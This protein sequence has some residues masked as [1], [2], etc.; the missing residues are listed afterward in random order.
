MNGARRTRQTLQIL[1]LFFLSLLTVSAAASGEGLPVQPGTHRTEAFR[2]APIFSD[3]MVLPSGRAV[4]VWG[5][6]VAGEK[7]TVSIARQQ[8]TTSIAADATWQVTLAAMQPAVDLTM[9][10][11]S[12]SGAITYA[13]VA[14]AK[15][16]PLLAGVCKQL[17]DPLATPE[18][19]ALFHN[20]KLYSRRNTLI[21]QQDPEV[22]TTEQ[23]GET[24]M[25][26]TTGSDPA[27]W[28]SDFMHI[29]HQQNN[30]QKNWFHDAQAQI[31]RR[32]ST[33]YDR[34]MVNIFCWHFHEPYEQKTFNAREMP[35]PFRKKAFRSLLPGGE[36][37]NWYKEKLQKIAEVVGAI[38]GQNG[39]LSPVIFRPFHEFDGDWFW[40]GKPYCSAQ[41]FRDCWRFTVQYLRDDLQVHNLLYAFSPDCHFKSEQ[42]YL[43]RYPG[44]AY[45]DVVGFD[46]YSDFEGNRVG[47]VAKKLAIVS[48]YAKQHAKLAALTEVGYRQQPPPTRLYTGSYGAAFADPTL[49]IAFLMFWR[50]GK[51]AKGES[52]FVPVP[53]AETAD[54]FLKFANGPRPL[55]LSG[56][57]NLYSIEA[58]G[59]MAA[60]Q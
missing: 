5:W 9:S 34:G 28:G 57:K 47:A 48:T 40:W 35:A 56:V 49:E 50:Q 59:R 39:T 41:E 6:G 38:R 16:K 43:E 44:D 32:A 2:T 22:S 55:F 10:V 20:L 58:F 42:D 27:V 8:Q 21:G 3:G 52:Y 4:T 15:I 7:V 54:D 14:V 31:I 19:A 11:A 36:N 13:H 30:G 12:D 24:D 17:V 1:A 51:Q 46:D 26:R 37:H 45:V 18:T 60:G 29:T 25:H 53:A 23:S 33:T